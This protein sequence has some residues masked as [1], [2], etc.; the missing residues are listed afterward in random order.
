MK[1]LIILLL[2]AAVVGVVITRMT[3]PEATA[4][5]TPAP[6]PKTLAASPDPKPRAEMPTS[7]PRP[8]AVAETPAPEPD[9]SREPPPADTRLEEG[10]RLLEAGERIK[11]R[12]ILTRLYLDSQGDRRR[13]ARD[14][15][16]EINKELVFNPRVTA[17]AA[18]HRV[19]PGETL[20]RIGK[21]YGVN[22]RMIARL[23]DMRPDGLLKVEQELKVLTGEPCV[24]VDL[25][26]FHLAL[27][28]DGAFIKE[29]PVGI[30]KDDCTPTGEF[31]VDNLLVRPRWY[32]PDGRV[33]EYGEEGH[34]LGERWIGFADQPGASGLGIHGTKGENG[35]GEKCS[36][37]CIRMRNQDVI[38]LYD[39][40]TPGTRVLIEE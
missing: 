4:E 3:G 38:E 35:I 8:L 30:G 19:K 33:V 40:L 15:L 16:R 5:N 34:L 25:S 27:L 29:Y 23:N 17:G 31:V 36:N 24:A 9:T 12:E 21:H 32:A 22:W 11:A 6:E 13:K 14:V 37:G 10:K 39:F 1:N 28:F 2:A 7:R 18:V 20:T 26:E